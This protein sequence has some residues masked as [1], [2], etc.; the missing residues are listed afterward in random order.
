[1]R[2]PRYV[3]IVPLARELNLNMEH[4]T[5]WHMLASASAI[6]LLAGGVLLIRY[7]QIKYPTS[8]DARPKKTPSAGREAAVCALPG[9][10]C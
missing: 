2:F 7:G 8:E 10:K 1:M 3:A 6:L 9:A 4:L 5:L